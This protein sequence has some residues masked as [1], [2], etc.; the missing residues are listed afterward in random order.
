MG[1]V[2]REVIREKP[3]ARSTRTE[4]VPY[5]TAY[6]DYEAQQM[7]Y[8]MWVPVQRKCMNYYTVEHITEYIPKE[9]EDVRV[10]VV[11]EEIV[12]MRVQYVP[13]ERY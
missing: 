11:P 8:S 10:E 3:P 13:V 7:V 2:E 6:T 12:N 9:I 1:H 5:E 4:Y